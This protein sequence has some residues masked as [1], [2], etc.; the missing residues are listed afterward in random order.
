MSFPSTPETRQNKNFIFGK[1]SAIKH[2]IMEF[3]IVKNISE[4]YA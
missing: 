4:K 1:K 3:K 2:K